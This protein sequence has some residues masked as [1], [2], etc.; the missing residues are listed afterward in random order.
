MSIV[1]PSNCSPNLYE[2]KLLFV[3]FVIQ[4]KMYSISNCVEDAHHIIRVCADS[5]AEEGQQNTR[6][7][8][9]RTFI[10]SQMFLLTGLTQSGKTT[11][12]YAPDLFQSMGNYKI[13]RV[14]NFNSS[15][16]KTPKKRIIYK[17][18]QIKVEGYKVG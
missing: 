18:D 10:V 2:M 5:S 4:Q 3:K 15:M 12:D 17:N 9:S 7:Q 14:F 11:K 6:T 8:S 13:F 1:L 16:Q